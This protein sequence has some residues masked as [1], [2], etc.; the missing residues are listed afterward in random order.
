MPL[1][2]ER[3]FGGS[4][5]S[6]KNEKK[7]HYCLE[8]PVGTGFCAVKSKKRI[9]GLKLPNLENRKNEIQSWQTKPVPAGFGFIAPDWSPRISYS[10]TFD[11]NWKQHRMP[12]M[13]E[14]FDHRFNNAA[15]PDLV[16]KDFLAGTET[17]I[18]HN[19]HPDSEKT[20]FHLPGVCL[21]TAYIYEHQ[22]YKPEP[23]LDTLIIEPDENLFTMVWRSKVKN[24]DKQQNLKQVSVYE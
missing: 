20:V 16:S 4:D 5:E 12:L 9:K 17:V 8:N 14:D 6:H 11:E 13:P 21:T 15:A 23:V 18:L 24:P 10:G 3:A 2:Y 19:L 7:H 22:T 1:V